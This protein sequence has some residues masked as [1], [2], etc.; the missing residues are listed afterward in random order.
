MTVNSTYPSERKHRK[1]RYKFDNC[2]IIIVHGGSIS[3]DFRGAPLPMT[4]FDVQH[5][6]K[7]TDSYHI[8]K[9]YFVWCLMNNL[10]FWIVVCVK[11][12]K[13]ILDKIMIQIN[14]RIFGNPRTLIFR[15]RKIFMN[16]KDSIVL[17]GFP[18]LTPPPP[19]V[20]VCIPD[21]PPDD[22][23]NICQGIRHHTSTKHK[24]K[25]NHH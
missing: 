1:H 14:S 19:C 21:S 6:S 22:F 5:S 11:R 23:Q 20:D 3:V 12:N 2:E 7:C 17:P 16:K 10:K 25:N 4:S 8:K 9:Q 15:N 13:L 24:Q 18:L